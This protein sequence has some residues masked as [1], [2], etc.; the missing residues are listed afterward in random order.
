MLEQNYKISVQNCKSVKRV[1]P[2]SSSTT[3]C[4]AFKAAKRGPSRHANSPPFPPSTGRS[5]PNKSVTSCRECMSSLPE[6]LQSSSEHSAEHVNLPF[7]P[8]GWFWPDGFQKLLL[9]QPPGWFFPR[10]V[11]PRGAQA[12]VASVPAESSEHSLQW[13]LLQWR[14]LTG[15]GSRC[16]ALET[17]AL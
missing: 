4:P 6:A 5:V 8:T 3:Q 10:Q 14:S 17:K 7:A 2:T 13:C 11:S 9:V 1:I 16:E 12:S 15:Y